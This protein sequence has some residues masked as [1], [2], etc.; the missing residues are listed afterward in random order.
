MSGASSAFSGTRISRIS[1]RTVGNVRTSKSWTSAA[2]GGM[3]SA[4]VAARA[5]CT[6]V[7]SGKPSG[8]EREADE[9]AMVVHL[10]AGLDEPRDRARRS[11]TRRRRCAARARARADR[12]SITR[13]PRWRGGGGHEAPEILEECGER[14]EQAQQDPR[15]GVLEERIVERAS[16]SAARRHA[17]SSVSPQRAPPGA[18]SAVQRE[19]G[20]QGQVRQQAERPEL[21]EHGHRRGV[22]VRRGDPPRVGVS[23]S[24]AR[25]KPPMPAPPSGWSA[26]HAAAPVEQVRAVGG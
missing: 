8:S 11:R 26:D 4:A 15:R 3:P 24:A 19:R 5:S 20:Q 9:N 7:S 2:R 23:A 13:W 1:W 21:G 12:P 10:G 22:R 25:A 6:S 14:C 18:G 16:W 17:A